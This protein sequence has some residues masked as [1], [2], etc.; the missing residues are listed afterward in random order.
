MLLKILN[1][2]MP[3]RGPSGIV[4]KTVPYQKYLDQLSPSA[5]EAKLNH[6]G[7][8]TFLVFHSGKIIQSGLSADFMRDDFYEFCDIINAA[9]KAGK[10]EEK[11][12]I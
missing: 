9:Y 12:D 2:T 11:L 4:R 1:V 7:Y 3:K 8:N 6:T 10:I 5:R